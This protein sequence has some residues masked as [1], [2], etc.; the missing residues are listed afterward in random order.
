MPTVTVKVEGLKQLDEALG[1]LG[2]SAGKSVLRRI[3]VKALK[4]FDDRWRANA[5]H[6]TGN[7]E[8]S[9]GIGTKL[10]RRQARLNRK[11]DDRAS[12]EVFSGP[13][14]PAA[15]P[16]EF[17]W[18]DGQAQ[19]FMRPAWDATKDEV[20]GI[21]KRDLGSEIQKTAERQ[22]RRVARGRS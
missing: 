5:P 17:G 9:G 14:D 6:L 19:P 8:E 11:R 15:V 13:N 10:T 12:V 20:L 22:A 4:P 7:L 16:E 1:I 21:V 2:K 18:V 3:A